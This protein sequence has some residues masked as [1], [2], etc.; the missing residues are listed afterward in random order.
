MKIFP[1][2]ELPVFPYEERD[3][4]VFFDTEKFKTRIIELESGGKLPDCRMKSHV[5]FYGISGEANVEVNGEKAV[6]K[7]GDCLISEPGDFSL[8]SENG[9]RILGIQ[10]K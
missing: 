7:Q 3:K 10:I 8:K 4:N 6:L 1:L 9:V 2:N 5:I